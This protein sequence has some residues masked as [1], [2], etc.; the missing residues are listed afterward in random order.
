MKKSKKKE[1]TKEEIKKIIIAIIIFALYMC[2]LPKFMDI[3]YT[4]LKPQKIIT[5]GCID[6]VQDTLK[7]RKIVATSIALASGIVLS[8]ITAISEIK[9]SKKNKTFSP[10]VI[11]R[12]ILEC[13]VIFYI[14]CTTLY[15]L[16][17]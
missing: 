1:L 4:Y 2:L 9:K 3:V 8:T 13:I 6:C 10:L 11:S 16:I 17:R 15:T 5:G 7:T 12:I 14:I